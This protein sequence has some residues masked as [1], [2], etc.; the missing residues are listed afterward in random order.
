MYGGRKLP[1]GQTQN[2]AHKAKRTFTEAHNDQ[3]AVLFESLKTRNK[4]AKAQ[5]SK[6]QKR[7]NAKAQNSKTTPCD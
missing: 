3:Y 6:T 4:N 5:N 2:H 7:K 1:N